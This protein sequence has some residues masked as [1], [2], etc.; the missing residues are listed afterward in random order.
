MEVLEIF[1]NNITSLDLLHL[2]YLKRLNVDRN[3]ISHIKS[4]HGHK[5]IQS[6]SW[7]DQCSNSGPQYQQS[8]ELRKLYLSSNTFSYF[9]PTLS[10][11]NLQRLEISSTGLQTLSSDFGLKC[12]NLRVVNFNYNALRDLRPLLGITHLESL[13]LAGNRISRL[14]RTVAVL[15]RIG[16]QLVEVDLRSNPLTVGFYTPQTSV[17]E[18]RRMITQK[19]MHGSEGKDEDYEFKSAKSHLLPPN[20]KEFDDASR[21][22]L[23]EDTKLR[24]RVFE[25]LVVNAC[26]GLERLDGLEIDRRTVAKRDDIWDRLL[27]LGV[28]KTKALADAA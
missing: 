22:R 9:A 12:P 23:D 10:F 14:R 11:L 28:L 4:L 18:E 3:S 26:K 8:H 6:L 5:H 15:D 25:M 17:R 2:P 21:E 27:E 13:S 19:D 16:K 20:D 1:D 7:R 24:R